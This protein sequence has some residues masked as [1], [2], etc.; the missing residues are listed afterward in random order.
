M[1]ISMLAIVT[2]TDVNRY[3]DH[4]DR[5]IGANL[6]QKCYAYKCFNHSVRNL[7]LIGQLT[8]VTDI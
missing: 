3:V 5:N 8:I 2:K 4:S 6:C 7:M 1:L